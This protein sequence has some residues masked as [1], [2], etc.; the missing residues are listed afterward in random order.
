MGKIGGKGTVPEELN[1]LQLSEVQNHEVPNFLDTILLCGL[2]LYCS[3][4]KL[5][6]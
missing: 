2:A 5:Y 3:S 4:T 1:R 6:H